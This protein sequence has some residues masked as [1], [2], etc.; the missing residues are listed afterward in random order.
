MTSLIDTPTL[1]RMRH[2]SE[3]LLGAQAPSEETTLLIPDPAREPYAV[4]GAWQRE[5]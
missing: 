1:R 4:L 5:Q 2:A 3:R